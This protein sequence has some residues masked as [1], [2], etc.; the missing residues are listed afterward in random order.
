MSNKKILCR[1]D[2]KEGR[3]GIKLLIFDCGFK[4]VDERIISLSFA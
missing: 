4:I 2:Q 1:N 3:G